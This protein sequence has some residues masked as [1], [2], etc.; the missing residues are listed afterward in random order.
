MGPGMSAFLRPAVAADAPALAEIYGHHVRHGVGTFEEAVP[1]PEEMAQRLA[2]VQARG[3]PYLVAEQG[4]R[5]AAFAYASPFRLRAAY[6]YT[7]EDSVYVA[8]GLEGQGLGRL[9]LTAV[10]EACTGLGLRQMTALIGDSGNAASI[11]LHRALGFSHSGVMR[12][13]GHKAGRWLDVVIM[14]LPLGAGDG[15]PP[16]AAGMTL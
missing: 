11:G 5:M 14:Q 13:V 10:I 7:V 3:L 9:S 16:D 8:P 15:D 2:A 6:R 1:S 12:A 4:G